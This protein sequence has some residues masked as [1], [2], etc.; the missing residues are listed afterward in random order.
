[1]RRASDQSHTTAGSPAISDAGLEALACSALTLAPFGRR[2][3]AALRASLF[4][5][6]AAPPNAGAATVANLSLSRCEYTD[7]NCEQQH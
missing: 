3:V 1:M 7:A 2:K 4:E 6:L 5:V